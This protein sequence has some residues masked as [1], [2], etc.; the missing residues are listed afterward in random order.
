MRI[1]SLEFNDP[2]AGWSLREVDFFRD[3]TLLVGISGVGKTRILDSLGRLKAVAEGKTSKKTFGINWRLVFEHTG[4]TYQ[5][6]GKFTTDPNEPSRISQFSIFDADKDAIKPELVRECLFCD[7]DEVVVREGETITLRGAK[8]PKLSRHESVINI[9][10]NED[11]VAPAASGLLMILSVNHAEE[12]ARSYFPSRNFESLSKK[13][14][15]LESIRSQDIPTHV[16][17][18]LLYENCRSD[19]DQ[20]ATQFQDAFPTVERVEFESVQAGPFGTFPRMLL[21]ECGVDSAIPEESISS[22]MHRTLLHLSRMVL[23]PDGTVVLIDEF[24]N[25]L[26]INCINFVTQNLQIHSQR[27][28]FILTSHHPYI[29]NNISMANWKIVTRKGCEVI[30]ESTRL[31]HHKSSHES[32]LQLLNSP[33]Y[34]DGISTQ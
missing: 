16:K 24:E 23:W 14:T 4:K 19:F 18:A 28:Q 9:L 2:T 30:V 12:S 11:S 8:T 15:T 33:E 22:G 1:I 6:E 26:G 10:R 3:I 20:I 21:F 34:T 13:Y 32:F 7:G 31:L 29:I 27:M 17:L 25:S 5:W